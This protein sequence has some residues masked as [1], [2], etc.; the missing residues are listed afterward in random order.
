MQAQARRGDVPEAMRTFERLRALLRDELGTTPSPEFV[1]LHGRLLHDGASAL[2]AP[3][4]EPAFAAPGL[5]AP[6]ARATGESAFVGRE[7]ALARLREV[8]ERSRGGQAELVLLVGEPGIGKTRLAAQF[9]R[10]VHEAGAIVLYGRADEDALLPHQPFVE[11]LR[12]LLAAELASLSQEECDLLGRLSPDL[13]PTRPLAADSGE[14][15]TLRYRL[16][17]AVVDVLARASGRAPVLLLLDDLHWADQPT[18]LLLRHLLRTPE[19]GGALVVA[20]LREVELAAGHALGDALVDIR[21]DRSFER[22]RIGG[23]ATSETEQL[24][25]GRLRRAVTPAFVARLR[26]QTAGNAFFIEEIL[27]ALQDADLP[28][29][30]AVGER[31][32]DEIGVPDGVADVIARRLRRLSPLAADALVA[33]AVAGR[34]FRLDVVE[35]LVDAGPEE[36]ILALEESIAAGLIRELASG[37]DLFAFS[38][39]LVRDVLYGQL[40]ASR[41][42][43]LHHRV[44]LALERLAEREAVNPA[45][46]AHHFHIARHLAGNGPARRYAIEAGAHASELLAYEEAAEHFRRALALFADDEDAERCDVLLALGRVQWHTG[47]DGA[48]ATFLRAA[49]S[50]SA[51]GAAEQLARA[52]LGLGERWFEAAYVEDPRHRELLEAAAV[53]LPRRDTPL[54][55]LVLSRL[56]QHVGFPIEHERAL[57]LSGD[58]LAMA[59]RI[60]GAG[61]LVPALLARYVTL[62]DVGHLDERLALMDELEAL[63]GEHRELAAEHHHW[64]L[65]DLYELGDLEAARREH[66]KLDAL[67]AELRQPLLCSMAT[68]WRGLAA[69]LAGDVELAAACAT[70]A[71]R[72]GRRAHMRDATSTWA[73]KLF[74]ARH[75]DDAIREIMPTVVQLAEGAGRDIAWPSALAVLRLDE[76]DEAGARALYERELARG[77]QGVPRGMYRLTTLVLLAELCARLGDAQRAEELYEA[78]APFAHRNVVV[79]YASCWGPVEAWLAELADAFGDRPLATRHLRSALVRTRAMGAPLLTA[80]LE[81]RRRE[82]ARI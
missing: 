76:G 22:I 49:E 65:Y 35:Q 66:G 7:D 31:S 59:R 48:R 32:L 53:A 26:E 81:A 78:L 8:W 5:P 17:Q 11:A 39:V 70:D 4:G 36:L 74:S 28:P 64:R 73:A 2:P 56:A 30:L 54:R 6:V 3:A 13:R 67:A 58:A 23:F 60:G 68:G 77:A 52:A 71:L 45:E 1:E 44:A 43:R 18:L 21:R 16:F 61:A 34:G 10:E 24:V 41:R 80:Q 50:A 72:R 69:E 55:A 29:V 38:H 40:T 63:G 79:S 37:V 57:E 9:A 62:T 15:E 42:L 25:A 47:D 20:T 12:P 19:L 27:R 82:L 75:R 14:S 51:R 33:A 46:L